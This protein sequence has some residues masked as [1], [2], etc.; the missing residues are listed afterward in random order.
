MFELL[1]YS[2]LQ[3]AIVVGMFTGSALAILGIVVV[4]RR[5]AFFGS[6]L[7]HIAFG[8]IGLAVFLGIAPF[9]VAVIFSVCA[10]VFL[11][12]LRTRNVSE[13]TS[14]GILFSLSMALG[15]ILLSLGKKGY[16][17]LA[18]YLFG[19]ILAI[20]KYEARIMIMI[21]MVS[22]TFMYLF[23]D[24]L[25]YFTMDEDYTRLIYPRMKFVYFVYLILLA[26]MIVLALKILGVILVSALFIIPAA[27]GLIVGGEYHRAFWIALAFVN[28][29]IF[30]GIML[31]YFLDL[32]TGPAIVVLE[33]GGFFSILFL[34]KK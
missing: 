27:A 22:M 25:A 33:G 15:V 6:G 7:A 10:A 2:F 21:S 5:M 30:A 20:G 31:S 17:D 28:V 19:D 16:G 1:R 8:G 34:K 23:H 32:P 4:M 9:P 24:H 26:V 12:Y 14:I 18:S 13:D 11:G 29:S 3:R